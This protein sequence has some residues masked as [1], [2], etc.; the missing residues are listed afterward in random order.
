MNEISSGLQTQVQLQSQLAEA[1]PKSTEQQFDDVMR[2]QQQADGSG[3]EAPEPTHIEKIRME[4]E[5]ETKVMRMDRA[6]QVEF[7]AQPL[8][9]SY[10]TYS[11]IRSKLGHEPSSLMQQR[12]VERLDKIGQE[13]SELTG[14]LDQL[15]SGESFSQKE[16]L[17]VQIRSHQIIQS[18]EILSKSVE[19]SA[20]GMKTII[21]TNV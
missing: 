2:Q 13:Y 20:S 21:Q 1:Q 14:F 6:S 12:V 18:V 5:L 15:A 7:F 11:D 4:R 16:L 9:A 19:Q 17:A 3:L 10:K 8:D